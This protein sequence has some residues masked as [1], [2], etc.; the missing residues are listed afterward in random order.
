MGRQSGRPERETKD[1]TFQSLVRVESLI[2]LGLLLP[3]CVVIGWAIGLA[4]DH[5]L[6][7]HWMNVAGLILGAIAGFV[8]TIRIVLAH[9]KE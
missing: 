6:N 1:N 3:A 7:Q 4:L 9:S 5:W 2:Q 8:Q